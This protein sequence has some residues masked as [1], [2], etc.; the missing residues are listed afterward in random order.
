M[1]RDKRKGSK[2]VQDCR[3]YVDLLNSPPNGWGQH[4]HPIHGESHH[5]LRVL[6]DN[7]TW[8]TVNGTI[9]DI[10]ANWHIDLD[11]DRLKL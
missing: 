9:K 4:I 7:Y 8:E 3:E 6:Y 11:V 5:F 1:Q 2:L 10:F